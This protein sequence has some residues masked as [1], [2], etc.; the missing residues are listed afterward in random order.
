MSV[1]TDIYRRNK[2]KQ[3]CYIKFC[4]REKKGKKRERIRYEEA[5][6]SFGGRVAGVADG[7]GVGKSPFAN[8]AHSVKHIGV[9]YG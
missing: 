8:A 7:R 3:G 5:K 4:W 1:A 6:E 2:T 9:V